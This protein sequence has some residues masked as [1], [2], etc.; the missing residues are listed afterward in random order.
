MFT[1]DE[2]K[3][4]NEKNFVGLLNNSKKIMLHDFTKDSLQMFIDIQHKDNDQ[5][6]YIRRLNLDEWNR[7]RNFL[8]G[9]TIIINNEDKPFQPA[10]VERIAEE[11]KTNELKIVELNFMGSHLTDKEIK[12]LA[13]ALKSNTTV[14]RMFFS[15][16]IPFETS[17]D[18]SATNDALELIAEMVKVNRTLKKLYLGFKDPNLYEALKYNNTLTV[19]SLINCGLDDEDLAKLAEILK[20]KSNSVQEAYMASGTYSSKG[21]NLLIE[22]AIENKNFFD[23][24]LNHLQVSEGENK[25]LVEERV[26]ELE[27]ILDKNKKNAL[28]V[29]E[30]VFYSCL[31][32][33]NNELKINM[34]PLNFGLLREFSLRKKGIEYL[35]NNEIGKKREIKLSNYLKGFGDSNHVWEKLN[36]AIEKYFRNNWLTLTG[37]IKNPS[38]VDLPDIFRVEVTRDCISSHLK[39]VDI[40]THGNIIQNA[41][42]KQDIPRLTNLSKQP[43]RIRTIIKYCVEGNDQKVL[44]ELFANLIG[45]NSKLTSRVEELEK[46]LANQNS[47]ETAPT[48]LKRA[49]KEEIE[50][51]KWVKKSKKEKEEIL[52]NFKF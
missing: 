47:M 22:A 38:S 24:A 16:N 15:N 17:L 26:E 46:Q 48:S 51:G 37:I 2:L 40:L 45:E 36:E 44:T 8:I 9:K 25:A 13:E 12:L 11:L 18:S 27:Q 3:D 4:I 31:S 28:S 7:I 49:S 34:N 52:Q 29:A 42:D 23:I 19:F 33:K 32:M 1:Q 50:E 43:E 35:L 5:Y 21:I 6:Q 20:S 39:P 10:W 14:E 30:E 41:I